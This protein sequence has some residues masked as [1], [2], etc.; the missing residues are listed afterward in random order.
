V[1]GFFVGQVSRHRF[2]R[3]RRSEGRRPRQKRDRL[4]PAPPVTA[5]ATVPAVRPNGRAVSGGLRSD[6]G[7]I[8]SVGQYLGRAGSSAGQWVTS[9]SL[10]LAEASRFFTNRPCLTSTKFVLLGYPLVGLSRVLDPILEV[11]TFWRQKL[12]DLV[13]ARRAFGT[14]VHQLT[15]L[16]LVTAMR[17]SQRY[18][19]LPMC[20]QLVQRWQYLNLAQNKVE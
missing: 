19:S 17:A 1:K 12:S 9:A 4:R 6:P 20:P 13:S 10:E 3:P 5:S 2:R 11:I 16:K 8:S 14:V 7:V 15:D 18:Y